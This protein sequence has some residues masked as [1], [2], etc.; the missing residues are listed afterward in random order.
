[1]QSTPHAAVRADQK[2]TS[3]RVVALLIS[4]GAAVLL[5][6]ATWLTPSGAG[7]GTHEQLNLPQCGW[8]T[9]MNVPCPTCGMT[10]AF[11]HAA[12]GNLVASF[13]TQPLGCILA[14]V[15]AMTLILAMYVAITGSAIAGELGRLWRPRTGWV[16][17]SIVVVAW[18]YKV[19]THR[20]LL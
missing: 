15:T 6:V 7:L 10:T 8:I 12:D 2:V 3:R 1:V 16:L 17:A 18:L 19:S 11:A 13:I 5:G 14:L 4:F 9:M 20:G